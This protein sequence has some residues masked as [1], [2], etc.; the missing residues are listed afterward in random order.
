MDPTHERR[1]EIVKE[2]ELENLMR[3]YSDSLGN[4]SRRPIQKTS[5]RS[6]RPA[7]AAL[8]C[9]SVVGVATI[10]AW[11]RNATAAT[12]IHMRR[13]ILNA[14]SMESEYWMQSP[15]G[16]WRMWGHTYSR[17]GME[18]SDYRQGQPMAMRFVARDG[19]QL[20][21]YGNLDHAT[22]KP[23]DESN[24][25]AALSQGE[26]A[27]DYV[28]KSID[29][30]YAGQPR[31]VEIIRDHAPVDGK[32]A[33]ALTLDRA[34]DKYHA[35]IL[36]EKGND[37]PISS[38]I[39]VEHLSPYGNRMVR[40]RNFYH[41]N[42]TIPDSV[43]SL[44]SDKQVVNLPNSQAEL[45]KAWERPIATVEGTEVRD[46]AVMN[47][48][49][50]WIAVT[51]RDPQKPNELDHIVT[52]PTSL[53]TPEGVVYTRTQDVTPSAIMQTSH[54]FDFVEKGV[55]EDTYVAVFVPLTVNPATPKKVTV[56]FAHRYPWCLGHSGPDGV[57]EEPLAN[58][59]T[60][61][62]HSESEDRPSY[63]TALDLDH[64]GF[65]LPLTVWDARATALEKAG[66]PAE[67][68]SAWEQAAEQYRF[69]LPGHGAK[70]IKDAAKD[71]TAAGMTADAD[72][73]LAK[74]KKLIMP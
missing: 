31:T 18:R 49:S 44:K 15:T 63:F 65:Q 46:A 4:C 35:E 70:M 5:Q 13:A 32:A 22:L 52:L 61:A 57:T 73:A 25:Q 43:F 59:L 41:F 17:D 64:F 12:L 74:S 66:K 47:D 8:A 16:E 19:L 7:M 27:L 40:Y 1:G 21:D 58:P 39:S 56:S 53:T 60:L 38:E 33:Y 67:A 55:H 9:A 72:R 51:T 48:G 71:Y 50:I 68:A 23:L 29:M 36:V 42:R 28:K 10:A 45:V 34:A 62:V 14:K 11:P 30:G 54:Y 24:L 2:N 37:L 20:W 3:T 6:W 26:D 69:F